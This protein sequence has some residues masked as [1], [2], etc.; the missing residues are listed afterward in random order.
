MSPHPL[1]AL[2]RLRLPQAAAETVEGM[3]HATPCNR[4]TLGQSAPAPAKAIW[5][6]RP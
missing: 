4:F 3:P 1:F 2:Q 5:K 6:A